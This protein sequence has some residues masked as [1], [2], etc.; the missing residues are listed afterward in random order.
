MV[1]FFLYALSRI[2]SCRLA[3]EELDAVFF[4][5]VMQ[6]AETLDV[7]RERSAERIDYT[8]R[9]NETAGR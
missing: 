9:G 2:D 3:V 1:D 5:Q 7:A 4:R 8:V 6:V